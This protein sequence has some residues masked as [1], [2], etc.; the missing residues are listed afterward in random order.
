MQHGDADDEVADAQVPR[1]GVIDAHPATADSA[2]PGGGGVVTPVTAD[3]LLEE[4]RLSWWGGE[5]P[6]MPRACDLTHLWCAALEG[7]RPYRRM[8]ARPRTDG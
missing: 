5:P 3:G 1:A 8:T 4:L 7:P 6:P 2:A